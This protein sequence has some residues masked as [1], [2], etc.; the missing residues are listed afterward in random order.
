MFDQKKQ[1]IKELEQLAAANE[2]V[3]NPHQWVEFA[4]NPST[5]SYKIFEWDDSVAAE[6]WRIE[7]ARCYLRVLVVVVPNTNQSVR[8]WVS[9]SQ[10]R[11]PDG[12]YRPML[13]VLSKTEWREKLLADAFSDLGVIEAKYSM[14]QE[15]AEVFAEIK[16]AKKK[17]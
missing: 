14:L 8:A 4:R 17:K 15:L 12:G 13:A 6:Q 9:M 10:D 3:V 5:A 16:K 1:I 7:Q 2:G 11:K